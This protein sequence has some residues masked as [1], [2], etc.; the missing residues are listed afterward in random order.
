MILKYKKTQVLL[1]LE[2]DMNLRD[3]DYFYRVFKMPQKRGKPLSSIS[4]MLAGVLIERLEF[5]QP[6]KL[7]K[8]KELAELL[9]VSDQAIRDSLVQLEDAEFMI[10]TCERLE[11]EYVDEEYGKQIKKIYEDK[12]KSEYIQRRFNDLFF[13]NYFYN[14]NDE[15]RKVYNIKLYVEINWTWLGTY[16][17][18]K[19][20]GADEEEFE[21]FLLYIIGCIEE[22][23][24]DINIL[25]SKIIENKTYK[26]ILI[27][28]IENGI[29]EFEKFLIRSNFLNRV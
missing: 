27:E 8:R 21:K 22:K 7:P 4:Y 16:R 5:G 29:G 14:M 9:G 10:R 3:K 28:I 26:E 13:L 1:G 23:E 24:C 2:V 25:D 15:D 17:T 12:L 11:I 18:L 19:D 6:N 20:R